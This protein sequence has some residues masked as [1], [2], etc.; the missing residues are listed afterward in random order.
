MKNSCQVLFKNV[1]DVV[2][3]I[4]DLGVVQQWTLAFIS[5]I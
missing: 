5:Q 3:Y 2:V 4:R 1:T